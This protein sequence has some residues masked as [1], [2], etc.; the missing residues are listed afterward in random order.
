MS[1]ISSSSRDGRASAPPPPA[2][3]E[4]DDEHLEDLS[5]EELEALLRAELEGLEVDETARG[6][7]FDDDDDVDPEDFLEDDD[8]PRLATPLRPSS[9]ARTPPRRA[10]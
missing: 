8:A 10:S 3:D 4:E 6:V 9:T 1:K 5:D 2:A 7:V